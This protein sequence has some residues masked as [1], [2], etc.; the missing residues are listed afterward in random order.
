MMFG[1]IKKEK[2]VFYRGAFGE[3]LLCSLL[4]CVGAVAGAYSG[5]F[6]PPVSVISPLAADRAFF[7]RLLILILP[8][9]ASAVFASSVL[10]LVLLP[11]L[12]AAVGFLAGYTFSLCVLS[13]G[14][15][16]FV[17]SGN[18]QLLAMLPFFIALTA[19][20]LAFSR[21]L[22]AF[23]FKGT[24]PDYALSVDFYK[25]IIIYSAAALALFA[26]AALAG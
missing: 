12:A 24:R 4:L 8:G 1:F 20:S 14:A 15:F 17:T 9:L 3:L 6:S 7:T 2:P 22:S 23:F 19:H 16:S 11:A 21:A 25:S 18:W 26:Q 10:G 5:S 13:G